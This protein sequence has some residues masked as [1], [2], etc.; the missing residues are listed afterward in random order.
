M[1]NNKLSWLGWLF[2]VSSLS[3]ANSPVKAQPITPATDGTNTIVTPNGDRYDISGGSFSGDKANLFHSFTEFG[4]SQGQ[5]ANFLTNPNIQNILGRIN[6][7]NPSLINGLIQ[8]TGGNSNLFLMNPS[9]IIFGPNATLNVPGSFNA[10]A[11][12]GIGFGNNNW[13]SAIGPNNW[14]SLIGNPNTFAFT[15][16]Q[17]G[18]IVNAGNLTVAPGQNLTLTGG[19]V[20]NTGQLTAPGGNITVTAV[21]GQNLVRIAQTGNLLNLEIQPTA[22]QSS[23]PNNFAQPVLSLPQLLTGTGQEQATG[24]VVNPNG[25]VVLT[26]NVAVPANAGTAIASGNIN[27]S[28]NTG[29][30]V[31]IL[32][33][34]VG[35]IGGNID[36]SGSNGGGNVLIGGDYR[37]LGNVPNAAQTF[38]SRDSTINADAVSNGNGGRVI[39]WADDTARFNGNITARGGLLSGNGGFVEVSGKQSLDFQGVVDLRSPLGIAGTLLLDPTDITI[40]AGA[41]A[42]GTLGGVFVPAAGTSNINN[43]TLQNQL[44]LGSVTI[45]TESA[46]ASEGNITV[47][48]P[49][50]WN[51]NNSLTLNANNNILVQ[52]SITTQGGNITLNAD[53]DNLNGGNLRILGTTTIINTNGGNFVGIG[54]GNAAFGNGIALSGSTI[55]ARGGNINLNG[56]SENTVTISRGIVGSDATLQTTGIGTIT[57]NGT[58]GSNVNSLGIDLARTTIDSEDGNI[59]LAGSGGVI[60]NNN[61]GINISSNSL[62]RS[63]GLGNIALNGTGGN[64]TDDNSG[65]SINGSTVRSTA[66][67][68]INLTGTGSGTGINNTGVILNNATV[69]STSGNGSVIITGTGGN[70]TNDNAGITID[71]PSAVRSQNGDITLTGTGG[72]ASGINNTGITMSGQVVSENGD[73]ALIGNGVGTSNNNNGINLPA[74]AL[75]TIQPL[76]TGNISL[77]GSSA[78]NNSIPLNLTGGAINATGGGNVTLTGDEIELSGTQ[79]NSNGIGTRIIQLQP[80]TPSLNIT[81]GGNPADASL[82]LNATEIAPPRLNGFSRMIIGRTDGT[83]T[84]SIDAGGVTFNYP[85][86]IQSPTGAIAVNGNITGNNASITFRAPDGAIEVNGNILTSGNNAPINFNAATTNFLNNAQITIAAQNINFTGNVSL[87]TNSTVNL[88]TE[89]LANA[90][91][92]NFGGTVDGGGN[93][94]LS[95]GTGAI[96]INGSIGATIPLTSLTTNNA[97]NVTSPIDFGITATGNITTGSANNLGR[98]IAFTSTNGNIDTSEGDIDTRSTTGN[99]GLITFTA[100]NITARNLN[101]SSTN[102]TGGNITITGANIQMVGLTPVAWNSSSSSGAGGEV[103][104]TSTGNINTSVGTIDTTSQTGNGGPIALNGNNITAGILNSSA[105]NAAGD[106]EIQAPNT[107]AINTINAN[108]LFSTGNITINGNEI[109]FL[110]TPNSIQSRGALTIAP[111]SPTIGIRFQNGL[112]NDLNAIDLGQPFLNSLADGFSA[113]AIGDITTTGNITVENLPISFRDPVTFTTQGNIVVNQNQSIAGT[114]NA[115]ITLNAAT[116]N[117]NG[118]ITTQSQNITINGNAVIGNNVLVG[119]SPPGTGNILFNNNIDGGGNLTLETGT[120]NITVQGA[121]GNTTPLGNLTAN[122]SGTTAF[123][124]VTANS[125]TTNAGGTTQLNGNV[126]TTNS[127]TYGDAVTIATQNLTLAGNSITFNNTVNGN[128][129]LTVNGGTGNVTFAGAIGNTTPLGNIA[130]NTSGTTAFNGV[131]ANSLTTNAGGTTQLNGNVTT[132]NNQTYGD[133]VTIANNPTLSGSSITFSDTVNG[134]SNLIVNSSG[135]TNFAN[136]V[137][138]QSLTTDAGGTTTINANVTTTGAQTYGDAVTISNNPTFSGSAISFN[139]TVNGSNS[140][141]TVNS[142]AATSFANNVN[143]Q[144]LTTDAGGKTT[145]NGNVTTTGNQTYN[146]A[147]TITSQNPT[148]SGSAISFNNTVDGSN[149][150][151]T[152]NS[153]GAT[154]FANNVNLQSLTTDAIGTTT[155]NGNVSTTGAQTY[156]YA[157]T[158]SGNPI[159]SGSAISFNNTVNGAGNLTVNSSGATSF[160]NNVNLQNLTTDAGGTTTLNGNVTTTGNQTYNDAVSITSQT[161]TFSGSAISFNNTV[162]G[163]NSNLTVN[164]SGATS[165]ANNV[166]LQ[167]LTTDA[168]G[169]TQLNGNVTTTGNQTYGDAITIANNPTLSGSAITFN[170]TVNGSNSNLTAIGTGNVTFTGAV[171]V[172]GNIGISGSNVNLQ[173]LTTTNNGTLTLSNTGNVNIAGNLNLDGAFTQNGAGSVALAGNINTTNDN[174]SFSGPVTLNAPVNF[175]LGNATITFGSTVSA[176]NNPLN[177]TAGEIDFSGQVSGTNTLSLQPATAGQ[178]IVVGGNDNNTSALDLTAAEMSLLQNGF[179]SIALGNSNTGNITVSNNLTFADPVTIQVGSS[180]AL[181]GNLNGTDNSSINLSAPA[182]NLNGGI[183]ATNNIAING[184]VTLGSDVSLGSSGGNVSLTGAIDGNRRLN[185]NAGQGNVLLQG[186]IGQTTPIAGLNVAASNT[187]LGGNITADRGEIILNGALVLTTNARLSTAGGNIALGAIDSNSFDASN[188]TLN[189]GSGNITF[190]APVGATRQLGNILIENT[191]NVTANSTINAQSLTANSTGNINF[192]GDVTAANAGNGGA[193]VLGQSMSNPAAS[194]N[195]RNLNASGNTGGNISIFARDFITAGQINSSATV[196]NAGNVFLDPI[197]DI[198]VGFINAQGGTSGR[199]GDVTAIT[200]NFFRATDSFPTTFSPTGFASISTA[201]GSGSGNISITHAGGDGGTPIQPFVVGN[202]ANNGTAAAITTGQ[203]SITSQSFPRSNSVGNIVFSTDDG[204]DPITPPA[205]PVEP[206]TNQ[207]V[208]P[209]EPITNLPV[210]PAEP[211]TNPPVIPVEPITNLPVNPAEPIT[212]P[213][214]IPVEPIANPPVIPVEPI[215]NPPVTPT[216]PILDR[217]VIPVE[218]IANPPVT[219]VEPIINPPVTPAEPIANPSIEPATRSDSPATQSE[220]KQES[221]N[222][223]SDPVQRRR[224]PALDNPGN[225]AD[226]ILTIDSSITSQLPPDRVPAVSESPQ[227]QT[228]NPTTNLVLGYF[229]PPDRLFEDNNLEQTVWGIEQMRNQEFGEYLGIKFNIP[230]GSIRISKFQETLQTIEGKTG[231][232]SGIIYLVSR[233]EQL[234]I[235]L[236]PPV[237]QPIRYSVPEANKTALFPAVQRLQREVTDKNK[238]RTTSYLAPAQQLYKWLFAPLQLDLERL[239]IRTLLLSVDPGLR[240]LPFAALHDGKGF[241][242]EK[243]NFSLIP[244]FSTTNTEYQSVSG[245]TVLA[246][247]RSEFVDKKPLTGVPIE[248]Q[249]ITQE[250]QGQSFLN[251]TFTIDNLNSQHAQG[252]YRILHLATHAQFQPGKPSNSYIQLWNSKLDLDRME[253]VNWRNPQ[254]ELLVLSACRTALG[255]REAELGFGGLAVKSGAKSALGSL[256]YVDDL[257]TLGLMSEFYGQL[258]GVTIKT[259]ALQRAQQAMISGKLRVENGQLVTTSGS[260]N[261]PANLQQQNPNLAHPYYWSGFTAIGNPW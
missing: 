46:F 167:S 25:D 195:V 64:G 5:V 201:G 94:T 3:V 204:I 172:G 85:V 103:N 250:W 8:V 123:N 83:G 81:V 233:D 134:N 69:E 135:A 54:R 34:R 136:N 116:N 24:L 261:L 40:S 191:G 74:G 255:D 247:G 95:T 210:N 260:L 117:L 72:N 169:T 231:R 119:I 193:I 23:L 257:G 49:I 183:T 90:G 53:S 213:P 163:S 121:I 55:D 63:T 243:Y 217:Q 225:A 76:G 101:S 111:S 249:R 184:N 100:N 112:P 151:L 150:N 190:G 203:S 71:P 51:N 110:G 158:I 254:V 75:V 188:L 26:G 139:N 98:A 256:W 165:F 168:G 192:A 232:R 57:I 21:P 125:L 174:I 96:N 13:F 92:I 59:T 58:S 176:G 56:V 66:G 9:G 128:S 37:G 142:S 104:I 45:S 234:E 20:V 140:N 198:Q 162:N 80:L 141:L 253:S 7:G 12:T 67:G 87:A 199:G 226:R 180:I 114:D 239:G 14:S 86:T 238:L 44:A 166:N 70:G 137:N 154:S 109:G 28:G 108:G 181:N 143:L 224:I 152:V 36:A 175:G 130:A 245:A 133:A 39:V 156:G 132:T 173:S 6:G 149:S 222:V 208:T 27:V 258:R 50:A 73:I 205:T 248:L 220:P 32:G 211:I 215:A 187:N 246:M 171:S 182:L 216:E 194:V 115:S 60:G 148:L 11:A 35:V 236:V 196:G 122:T 41:D 146:D 138:L 212:N 207:P 177:L 16:S 197:G 145:L 157:V 178:N 1:R 240:S 88:N 185:I 107:V 244:S 15:N 19:T 160:A 43:L 252:K 242:I 2:L 251:S 4:L 228:A 105:P 84:I 131:T 102:G 227:Q 79:I 22:N 89:G 202:A 91:D 33:D 48:A 221:N 214:V 30:N 219:P 78:N 113:I 179:S 97:I 153:S 38:V 235:I 124:A 62:V 159:L 42:G 106:I 155:I 31:N 65:I 147:V 170:N 237:G 127:Q 164:S 77:T 18:S 82:N 61:I 129:D 259:E 200:G 223:D 47:S 144:S 99:G 93:L 206:I 52:N 126:T 186:N 68:N 120:G 161:P 10:T 241:L 17:P 118:N 218:P 230:D 189:S 29:G 209:V 229:P